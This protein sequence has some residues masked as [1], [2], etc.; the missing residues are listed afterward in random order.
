MNG[1]V[2]LWEFIGNE[3]PLG[4][5]FIVEIE[6]FFQLSVFPNFRFDSTFSLGFNPKI[7]PTELL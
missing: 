6:N 7:V 2:P 4:A 3:L 5:V 1:K